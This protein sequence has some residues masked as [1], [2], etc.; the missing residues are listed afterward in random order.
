MF[1]CWWVF[2]HIKQ[3]EV[4]TKYKHPSLNQFLTHFHWINVLLLSNSLFLKNAKQKPQSLM[5]SQSIPFCDR[6]KTS[7]GSIILSPH[8]YNASLFFHVEYFEQVPGGSNLNRPLAFFLWR[9]LTARG[10]A[11]TWSLRTIL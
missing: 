2:K 1:F 9:L 8:R 11:D 6:R 3:I 5:N 10:D 7:Y 4:Y